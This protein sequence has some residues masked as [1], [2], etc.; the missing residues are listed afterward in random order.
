[1]KNDYSRVEDADATE[2]RL[3]NGKVTTCPRSRFHETATWCA[4]RVAVG[5]HK[6]A[7]S[8]INGGFGILMYHRVADK[9]PG[10]ESPS[11]NVTP[12]RL[13]EQLEGLLAQGFQFWPLQKVVDAHREWRSIPSNVVVVTF[14]DGYENNLLY[15]LP[16][17]EDLKIPATIF[18]ATAYLD[19]D[20][21]YPFENWSGAG[22][23]RVPADTWRPLTTAQ[24][25][26]LAEHE[27]I[28]LGAHTH[29][30]DAFA[31]R[32]DDFRRDLDVSIEILRDRFGVTRPTFSFP[33]GLATPEMVQAAR[34]ADISCALHTRPERVPPSLDPYHWGRFNAC[35]MD[36]AATLSAKLHGWYTPVADVLRNM[37]RPLAAIAPKVT[38]ELQA[39][40]Q[41]CFAADCDAPVADNRVAIS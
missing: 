33:F 21:P 19:S 36:T 20:G 35:D 5:L 10:I 26:I 29:T 22:S 3:G 39:L 41:P 25:Q 15:A 14:D 40:P 4:Q 32:V 11:V 28:E 38:G 37:K 13:R 18:I 9:P 23:T 27:L 8:R 16:I 7:G 17:L 2:S 12:R 34:Q 6:L 30:H 1:M 31:G 24:T